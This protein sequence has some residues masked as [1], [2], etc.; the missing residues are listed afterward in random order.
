VRVTFG[1][2]A[3]LGIAAEAL[4]QEPTQPFEPLV[5]PGPG[6]PAL[7]EIADLDGDGRG[8]LVTGVFTRLPPAQKRTLHVRYLR[9]D[10]TLPET[11]DWIAPMPEGAAAFDVAPVGTGAQE[12]FFL[13]RDRV[14][15]LSLAGRSPVWRDL[16]I[17]GTT[18]AVAASERGISRLR[19]L[20]PELGGAPRLVVP[21]LGEIFVVPLAGEGADRLATQARANY[22][23]PP[24]PGLV[25]SDNETELYF[26]H[27]RIDVADVDGDARADLVVSNRHELLVFR[28][29]ADARFPEQPDLR[30]PLRRL[31]ETD[32]VRASG[33]A[34]VLVRDMSGD[35][36]ADLVL[37]STQ[38]GIFRARTRTTLHVNRGGDWDLRTA[39]QSFELASGLGGYDLEDLDSDGRLELVEVLVRLS[40][41]DLIEMLLTRAIDVELRIYR[42]AE[43]LPFD[44]RPLLTRSLGLPISFETQRNVGFLPVLHDLNGDGFLDRFSPHGA[45]EIEVVLG[46]PGPGFR[47]AAIRQPFD[48]TGA[49]RFGDL[50]GDGLSDFVLHDPRRPGTP[51]RVGLNRGRLPDSHA[52]TTLEAPRD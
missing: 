18:V 27:P 50:D 3:L 43:A 47:D 23:V 16:P 7:A 35:G 34:R 26:E 32:L 5:L 49:I 25:I 4:A 37:T 51:I 24:R 19:L 10:G 21:G 12:L 40:T 44:P 15:R 29:R 6:R 33:N 13:Q 17:A 52:R 8:D 45:E 22:F 9:A 30:R 42:R 36:R 38:G 20:R 11:P 28:Q 2:F 41:L 31:S 46:A 48:A 1:I 39:D 14:T